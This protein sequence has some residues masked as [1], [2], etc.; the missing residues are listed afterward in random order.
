[1]SFYV[2][3]VAL[4]RLLKFWLRWWCACCSIAIW[5]NEGSRTNTVMAN[6]HPI[7]LVASDRFEGQIHAVF[8][9][10]CVKL[11]GSWAGRRV[12]FISGLYC[13]PAFSSSYLD[14]GNKFQ[15][16]TSSVSR[17]SAHRTSLASFEVT[18]IFSLATMKH[19]RKCRKVNALKLAVFIF[20][21]YTR[22]TVRTGTRSSL[23]GHYNWRL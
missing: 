15:N 14:L 9:Q 2:H 19:L 4:L 22:R 17:F 23:A 11:S 7:L 10:P 3:S 20:S 8:I 5:H 1:M 16:S 21:A 6:C 13:F 12:S 18:P